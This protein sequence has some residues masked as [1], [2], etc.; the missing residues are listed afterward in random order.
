MSNQLVD[1]ENQGQE[2]AAIMRGANRELRGQRDVIAS[3]ADKTKN[4]QDN[5]KLGEN[6][7]KQIKRNEFYS[8]I[9]LYAT[10][11]ILFLTDITM[12]VLLITKTF[13]SGTT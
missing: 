7:V 9:V 10:I 13:S 2:T 3:A 5:L 4:M 1:I 6:V 8:R 12:T 11:F